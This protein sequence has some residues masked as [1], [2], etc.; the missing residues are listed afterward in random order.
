MEVSGNHY[1]TDQTLALLAI[2]PPPSVHVDTCATSV[3]SRDRS[4]SRLGTAKIGPSPNSG[5]LRESRAIFQKVRDD[6]RTT[7]MEV[8]RNHRHT[9]ATIRALGHQP[10][11][12]RSRGH[13]S[14]FRQF[15]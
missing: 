4:S 1:H 2:S 13:L 12:I 14:D 3:N 9:A 5:D 15:P 8:S 7:D 6:H 11:T 10:A